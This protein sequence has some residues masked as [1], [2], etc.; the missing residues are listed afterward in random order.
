M[1]PIRIIVAGASRRGE[2]LANLFRAEG[3]F[4]LVACVDPITA[5]AAYLV[6]QHGWGCPVFADIHAA[7]AA[8]DCDAV[9]VATTDAYHAAVAVP[10]LQAGKYV[11]CE[12]PLD[13][14]AE[15]CGA[16]VAADA[17]AGGK[18][19]VGLNLRYA[20]VYAAI[21]RE[22]AAGT[23]GRVL[24]IQADEFY[25]GG[26]TYFRR[27]NRLREEGGGL[28][29]TKATHDFD[30]LCWMAGVPVESVY[31]VGARTHYAP[32][33][34]APQRCRDCALDC[35]DRAG[36]A[37]MFARLGEDATG[38]PY[39]LC[40]YNS[41]GDTFDHGIATLRHA[42]DL[43]STYT[44]NVVSGFTDRRLR[45]SG[46]KGTLDG[47]LDENRVRLFRRDPSG[48]EEVPLLLGDGGHGGADGALAGEFARFVRGEGAPRCRPAEA[49]VSVRVGLAATR[50][51]DEGR[52]VQ[53]DEVG[54][55]V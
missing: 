2:Y 18:T 23:V 52:V 25:N 50:S 10:A 17:A 1:S 30:L 14:T 41:D 40:L 38:Q 9:M 54:V 5:R 13:T 24:T 37:D 48:E 49:A 16:I 45:V 20:P 53:M 32:R 29:I 55:G 27:W 33:P 31:A 42:G 6:E 21:H 34:D 12:K 35:P 51:M 44:C 3:S 36:A 43:L 15:K 28:W 19:F 4:Q 7:L 47:S 26:R 11:F 46:T 39:D 22:I 8:V